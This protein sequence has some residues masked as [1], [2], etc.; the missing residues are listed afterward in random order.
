MAA[1][2]SVSN[3]VTCLPR[4]LSFVTSLSSPASCLLP[5]RGLA[6]MAH[7]YAAPPPPCPPPPPCHHHKRCLTSLPLPCSRRRESRDNP[8]VLG[9]RK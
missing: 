3:C 6:C 8:G 7:A 2:R 9:R 4:L 1:F 5:R